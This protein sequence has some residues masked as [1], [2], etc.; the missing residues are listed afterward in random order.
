M[1]RLLSF[2]KIVFWALLAVTLFVAG[3]LMATVNVLTPE[4]LTP[5][6]NTV[7]NKVLNA[8]VE[9]GCVELSM[10]RSWPFLD[11]DVSDL[12]VLSNDI[13]DLPPQVRDTLP[14]W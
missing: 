12:S 11:V 10:R 9:A 7:A 4:R 1:R 5:I 14:V 13:L 3:F 2:L 6:V 8:K